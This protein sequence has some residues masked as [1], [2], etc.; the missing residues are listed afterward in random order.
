MGVPPGMRNTSETIR[1]GRPARTAR[2]GFTLLEILTAVAVIAI[3]MTFGLP[4][5]IDARASAEL[6]A[7]KNRVI[8]TIGA[9]RAAAVQRSATSQFRVRRNT[10]AVTVSRDGAN[11]A[12]DTVVA[13]ADMEATFGVRAA[14]TP[15]DSIAYSPRGAALGSVG[16]HAQKIVLV[17]QGGTRQFQDSIC[18]TPFGLVLPKGCRL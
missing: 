13:A 9:A 6:Q 4:R 14:V 7:A 18:V 11:T 15:K 10:I 17:R 16:R 3:G 2:R 12:F 1:A 8:A 5:L